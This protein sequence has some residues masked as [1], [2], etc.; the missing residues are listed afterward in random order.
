MRNIDFCGSQW[1]ASVSVTQGANCLGLQHSVGTTRT[2]GFWPLVLPRYQLW[3]SWQRIHYRLSRLCLE[4]HSLEQWKCLRIGIISKQ[5]EV[6]INPRSLSLRVWSLRAE[7]WISGKN[8]G[9]YIS[10]HFYRV[11]T[12]IFTVML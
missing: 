4:S 8:K 1:W 3:L 7:Y 5:F 11:S 9:T 6:A 10:I 2:L 12:H